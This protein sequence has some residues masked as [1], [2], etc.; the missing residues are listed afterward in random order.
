MYVAG[1][2]RAVVV[3]ELNNFVDTW[4]DV[5]QGKNSDKKKQAFTS[6]QKL[7]CDKLDEGNMPAI[8]AAANGAAKAFHGGQVDGDTLAAFLISVALHES[9]G[10]KHLQQLIQVDG[11]LKP[12]GVGRSYWMLEPTTV[13]DLVAN[14]AAHFGPK[15]QASS[16]L[17]L[18]QLKDMCKPENAAQLAAFLVDP[19]NAQAAAVLAAWKSVAGAQGKGYLSAFAK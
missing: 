2:G 3:Q 4:A 15:A 13:R 12:H 10:G 9:E 6:H 18:K 11:K 14:S 5:Y 8:V 1:H 19:A 7:Y 17:S 16:G